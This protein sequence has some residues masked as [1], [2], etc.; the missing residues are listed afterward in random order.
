MQHFKQFKV[1]LLSVNQKSRSIWTKTL[2]MSPRSQG[3]CISKIHTIAS[4]GF[5]FSESEMGGGAIMV[6]GEKKASVSIDSCSNWDFP[7]ALSPLFLWNPVGCPPAEELQRA[8]LGPLPLPPKTEAKTKKVRCQIQRAP[9]IPVFVVFRQ[10]SSAMLEAER[11]EWES[12]SWFKILIFC[13]LLKCKT[14]FLGIMHFEICTSDVCTS[15]K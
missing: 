7:E 13:S 1:V 14:L 9:E 15:A 12:L 6:P 10:P 4:T 11:W 5:L 2:V 8:H 3:P